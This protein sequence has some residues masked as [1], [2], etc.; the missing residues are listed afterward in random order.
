MFT[1]EEVEQQVKPIREALLEGIAR[2]LA[3]GYPEEC[4]QQI[5]L[6]TCDYELRGLRENNSDSQFVSQCAKQLQR[7]IQSEQ[8][9]DAVLSRIHPSLL[10]I[11]SALE[12]KIAKFTISAI[13]NPT[14]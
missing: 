4:V 2:Y 9:M 14:V 8:F 7:E 5:V 1:D 13:T 11:R 6:T 3:E 10:G 12:N